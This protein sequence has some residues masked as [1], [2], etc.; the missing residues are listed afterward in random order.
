MLLTIVHGVDNL[1]VEPLDVAGTAV[2]AVGYFLEVVADYQKTQFRRDSRNKGKFISSGLW[3]YS[4]HPNYLGEMMMW[5]GAFLIVVH[6]LPVVLFQALAALGP[7]FIIFLLTCVSGIP[8]LE[9]QGEERWGS[10]KAY[11]DYKA[12]TSVLFLAPRKTLKA[13]APRAA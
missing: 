4:R 7:L 2:W 11:Q 13:E 12:R 10:T 8:L 9:K 6:A 5:V 3:V 1:A